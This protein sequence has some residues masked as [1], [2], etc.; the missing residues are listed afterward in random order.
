M[1]AL[2][3]ATI[4][5]AL[6]LASLMFP[7]AAVAQT[8]SPTPIT[9]TLLTVTRTP[10]TRSTPAPIAGVGLIAIVAGGAAIYGVIRRYRK[11]DGD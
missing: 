6:S 3:P 9:R 2:R 7:A 4:A 8:I 11:A 10:V 1:N 5:F